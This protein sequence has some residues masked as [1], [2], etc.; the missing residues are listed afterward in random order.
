[1]IMTAMTPS[2]KASS[3]AVE[4]SFSGI[5]RIRCLCEREYL[6]FEKKQ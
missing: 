1:V 2:E 3:R 5:R 4:K 6:D